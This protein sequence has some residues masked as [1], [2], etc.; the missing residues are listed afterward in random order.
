MA[1]PLRDFVACKTLK[2]K[3]ALDKA[4]AIEEK[5]AAEQLAAKRAEEA[6]RAQMPL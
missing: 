6:V 3:E 1:L 4:R 5:R 2:F